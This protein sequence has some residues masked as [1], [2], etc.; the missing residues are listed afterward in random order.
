MK[1]GHIIETIRI[2]PLEVCADPPL[3]FWRGVKQ[4]FRPAHIR[5]L[6][7]FAGAGTGDRDEISARLGLTHANSFSCRL[8][9]LRAVLAASRLPIRIVS[10]PEC[11]GRKVNHYKLEIEA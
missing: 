8:A 10:V 4:A 11:E 9:E 7:A 1:H 3:L 5:M 2:G 6:A